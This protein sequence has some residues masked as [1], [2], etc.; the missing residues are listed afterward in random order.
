MAEE[1]VVLVSCSPNEA[2]G[3]ASHLVQARVAACVNIVPAI[4]SI[5]RWKGE[6]CNE[7]ESLLV[8]KSKRHLWERLEQAI[9]EVHSYEVPEIICLP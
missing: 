2:E 7:T 3:I 6:L 5:Y 1:V 9:K 8:I 4:T